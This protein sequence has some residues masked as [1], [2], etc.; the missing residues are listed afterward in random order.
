MGEGGPGGHQAVAVDRVH[1]GHGVATHTR[2][3]GVPRVAA[4][5]RSRLRRCGVRR[6]CQHQVPVRLQYFTSSLLL[7]FRVKTCFPL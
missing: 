3:Q 1:D 6:Q 7:E 2:V 5:P 4:R